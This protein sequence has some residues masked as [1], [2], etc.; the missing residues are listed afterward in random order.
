[1][2]ET[3]WP[4]H[5][6]AD[7]LDLHVQNYETDFRAYWQLDASEAPDGMSAEEWELVRLL[8]RVGAKSMAVAR[9]LRVPSELA[10]LLKER[11]P[12]DRPEIAAKELLR[13]N[14]AVDRAEIELG[15][16]A[17]GRLAVGKDRL[18]LAHYFVQGHGLSARACAFVD[19][20]VQC[21]I[22]SFDAELTIMAR[23]VIEAAL[24]EAIDEADLAKLGLKKGRHGFAFWQYRDAAVKLGIL[25]EST[26]ESVD[27]IRA[28]GN[29]AVHASPGLHPPA[30]RTLATVVHVLGALFPQADD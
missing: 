15:G 18:L 19:R 16:E 22:W 12:W 3:Y 9:E 24:E 10:A 6:L 30:I 1:M 29:D 8:D 27:E 13:Y 21:F 28:A 11:R 17:V 20:M 26:L 23:A 4:E 7:L 2:G 14:V 25:N 5:S